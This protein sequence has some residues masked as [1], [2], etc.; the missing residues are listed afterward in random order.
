MGK[1]AAAG[2]I[3]VVVV[4]L[5]VVAYTLWFGQG[6]MICKGV[7]ISG[8]DV[9]DMP[10]AVA[11]GFVQRWAAARTLRDVT[12]TALDRRWH[13]TLGSLGLRVDWKDAAKRAYKVGP[14]GQDH[15]PRDLRACAERQGQE[16]RSQITL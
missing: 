16:H 6:D 10:C 13:G 3:A 5:V 9:G 7:S 2:G 4:A 1:L 8:V 14:S 11:S 15:Q 12:L